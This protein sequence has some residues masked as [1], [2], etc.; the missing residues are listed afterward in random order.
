MTSSE[1]AA[2][3][4]QL[5]ALTEAVKTV[6]ERSKEDRTEWRDGLRQVHDTVDAMRRDVAALAQTTNSTANAVSAMAVEKCG[7]RLDK[8]EGTVFSKDFATS[9]TRLQRLEDTVHRWEKWM[10][11]GWT[12]AGKLVLALI[13]SGAISG[14]AFGVAQK[15]AA[16]WH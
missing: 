16:H 9:T 5:G 15:I 10:G 1:S 11:R 13:A 14:G 4:T 7:E 12:F 3:A 6:V 8:I 2:V